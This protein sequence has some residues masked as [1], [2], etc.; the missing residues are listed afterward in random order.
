MPEPRYW[1]GGRPQDG[2]TK[3]TDF[4]VCGYQDLWKL[5]VGESR[6]RKLGRAEE[7]HA[8]GQPI[9]IL[10]ERDFFRMLS[11]PDPRAPLH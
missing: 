7:L 1:P 8:E 10:I 11:E 6:S 9:E 2:V 5:A 4:L 3:K